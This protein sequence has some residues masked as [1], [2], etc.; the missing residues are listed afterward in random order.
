MSVAYD[1]GDTAILRPHEISAFAMKYIETNV[2]E[3][4]Q[5][6]KL[7]IAA[8]DLQTPDEEQNARC[9]I[10]KVRKSKQKVNGPRRTS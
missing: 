1:K 2:E 5:M 10:N 7:I 4:A 9:K 3:Q 8:K 6:I